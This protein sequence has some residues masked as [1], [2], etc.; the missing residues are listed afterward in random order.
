MFISNKKSNER[1]DSTEHFS[2]QSSTATC[3]AN[4][5]ICMRSKE[6]NR[7]DHYVKIKRAV[8]LNEGEMCL[9][10]ILNMISNNTFSEQFLR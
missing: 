8:W 1:F 5:G 9:V 6:M 10:K 7:S 3:S 2:L 4:I